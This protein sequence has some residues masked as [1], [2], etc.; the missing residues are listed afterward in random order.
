M[1]IVKNRV[2]NQEK[3]FTKQESDSVKYALHFLL[4]RLV[5]L[6]YPIIPQITSVIAKD[7]GLNVLEIEYPKADKVKSDLSLI[8]KIMEFNSLVWKMKRDKGVSLREPLQGVEI[9]KELKIF[10][11]DLMACHNLI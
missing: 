1:E 3:K 5:I 6:L 4:E 8:D 11:K 2:Y 10:E 7:F 9:P